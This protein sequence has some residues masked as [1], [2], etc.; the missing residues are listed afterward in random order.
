MPAPPPLPP[1]TSGEAKC[2]SPPSGFW[3]FPHQRV[4]SR[5]LVLVGLLLAPRGSLKLPSEL[6]TQNSAAD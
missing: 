6:G 4:R 2:P 3:H 1:P 5:L